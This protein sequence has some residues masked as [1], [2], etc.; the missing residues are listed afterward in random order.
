MKYQK[1]LPLFSLGRISGYLAAK[2]SAVLY[3][4]CFCAS[5]KGKGKG[6]GG[7]RL[8]MKASKLWMNTYVMCETKKCEITPSTKA[9]THTT[10]LLP[11]SHW[12]HPWT[13]RSPCVTLD[14]IIS[15]WQKTATQREQDGWISDELNVTAKLKQSRGLR[16]TFDCLSS[17]IVAAWGFLAQDQMW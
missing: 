16:F 1:R 12:T 6:E 9:N 2:T 11:G 14:S 13:S 15:T 5:R 4:D 17:S 3:P 10:G 8:S 7:C